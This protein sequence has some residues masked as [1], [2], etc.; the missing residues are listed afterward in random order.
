MANLTVG[1][2]G[3]IALPD[4]LRERYDLKPDTPI[5]I[6]ETKAGILLIPLTDAPM[7]AALAEELAEWQSLS[8]QVWDMFP[9]EEDAP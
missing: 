5:R 9:Y 6:V 1:R 7:D 3:E 2:E 8:L 4:D